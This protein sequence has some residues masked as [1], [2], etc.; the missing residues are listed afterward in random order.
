MFKAVPSSTGKRWTVADDSG[1]IVMTTVDGKPRYVSKAY[2]EERALML[3]EDAD[4]ESANN[5][6][7][8]TEAEELRQ[9]VLALGAY[10]AAHVDEISQAIADADSRCQAQPMHRMRG[11]HAVAEVDI[12]GKL[13]KACKACADYHLNGAH[14]GYSAAHNI[15]QVPAVTMIDCSPVGIVPACAQCAE[16]YSSLGEQ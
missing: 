4:N 12:N 16:F 6:V 15:R 5:G 9:G 14:C 7:S 13:V 3:N 2:A 10:A 8:A 1:T 11:E